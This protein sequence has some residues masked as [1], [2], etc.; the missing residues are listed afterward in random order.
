[1]IFYLCSYLD[2]FSSS[3][4]LEIYTTKYLSQFFFFFYLYAFLNGTLPFHK[5]LK[6]NFSSNTFNNF[7]VDDYIKENYIILTEKGMQWFII[8]RKFK[9]FSLPFYFYGECKK[10]NNL[11]FNSLWFLLILSSYYLTIK[12]TQIYIYI[13]ICIYIY[14]CIYIIFR[15]RSKE[16]K[17]YFKMSMSTKRFVFLRVYLFILFLHSWM[18]Q[19]CCFRQ[20][21]YLAPIFING[22]LHETLTYSCLQFEWFSFC[23]GIIWRSSFC[24]S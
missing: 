17:K 20:R 5:K 13:Y 10:K 12:S 18:F 7:P 1:M 15:C 8:S 24:F 19:E 3:F 9:I 23:Y 21:T 4:V 16:R 14:L 2:F 22:L 6:V 11:K